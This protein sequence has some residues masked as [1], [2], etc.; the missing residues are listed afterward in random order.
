MNSPKKHGHWI[1]K[2]DSVV[3]EKLIVGLATQLEKSYVERRNFHPLR[4]LA[5]ALLA[6]ANRYAPY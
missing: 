6:A 5:T 2:I 3:L 1:K 4:D